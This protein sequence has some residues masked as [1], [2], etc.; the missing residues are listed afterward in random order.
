[1][2]TFSETVSKKNIDNSDSNHGRF[3]KLPHFHSHWRP[4]WWRCSACNFAN[5]PQFPAGAWQKK[6]RASFLVF[7]GNLQDKSMILMI[8]IGKYTWFPVKVKDQSSYPPVIKHGLLEAMDHRNRRC[9]KLKNHSVWG[10]SSQPSLMKPESKA[11]H[12]WHDLRWQAVHPVENPWWPGRW[13]DQSCSTW[14]GLEMK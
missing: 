7:I 6:K 12:L 9:S 14:N 8:F 13:L 4:R 1:M 5:S 2:L 10:C 3:Q 11:S